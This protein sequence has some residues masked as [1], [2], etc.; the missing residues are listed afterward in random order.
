MNKPLTVARQEFLDKIGN[1]INH[2]ELPA[3]IVADIFRDCVQQLD[4][5]ARQQYEAEKQQWEEQ[6]K[7]TNQSKPTKAFW[8]R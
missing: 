2:A 6:Q 8:D 1:I 3:F 7:K 5:I 4:Q